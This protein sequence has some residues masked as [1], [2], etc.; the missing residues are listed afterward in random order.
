M[1]IKSKIINVITAHPK[2]V[3]FWI[4]LAIKVVV[5]T[6]IILDILEIGT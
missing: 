4:G 1:S 5:G 6:P 3:I 2:L